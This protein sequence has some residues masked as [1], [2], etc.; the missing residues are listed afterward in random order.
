MESEGLSTC[1]FGEV[2]VNQVY[3]LHI[4]AVMV[5]VVVGGAS[6]LATT[7]ARTGTGTDPVEGAETTESQPESTK[8][9]E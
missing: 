4:S 3:P 1:F 5:G 2:L 7:L 9:T 8:F 6:P